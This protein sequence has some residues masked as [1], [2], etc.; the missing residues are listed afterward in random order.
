RVDEAM[1]ELVR[2]DREVFTSSDGSLDRDREKTFVPEG[3]PLEAGRSLRW[4]G[5]G[6][7]HYYPCA[8]T[9]VQTLGQLGTVSVKYFKNKKGNIRAAYLVEP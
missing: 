5:I 1:K 7:F 2:A 4:V 9:H 6:G 3:F 8:G